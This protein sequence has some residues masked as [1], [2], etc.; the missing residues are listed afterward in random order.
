MIESFGL[1]PPPKQ[2]ERTPAFFNVAGQVRLLA[3]PSLA[4]DH[5][6]Q[7]LR[8]SW[9]QCCQGDLIITGQA[10]APDTPVLQ[11]C[12]K[13][14]ENLHPQ[15]YHLEISEQGISVSAAN[16]MGLYYGVLT[17]SQWLTLAMFEEHRPVEQLRCLNIQDWPDYQHRG[18]M[19]DIS[20]TKV[21]TMDEL[22]R[23]I[24]FAASFKIN[25]IQLYME[26][27]FAYEGHD[28]VWKHAS[29]MDGS[30]IESLDAYCKARHIELVPNQNSFGH[31]HQWLKHGAYRDLAECPQGIEHPFSLDNEP[32]SLCPTDARTL[33]L[34]SDLFDQLL[35]HFSS[36]QFNVGLDETFDLGQGR[37][38]EACRERGKTEV[39]LDFLNQI[40]GLIA[41]KGFRM[42]FWGD[43][44]I[45]KPE[46]LERL[47]K[48]VIALEW[49][50]EADH[51][52][53]T[54]GEHFQRSEREFYVC[55]GTS[56][57]SSVI[58]RIDNA[59]AN[60]ASAAKAGQRHG[61]SGYLITDWGDYGHFQP[62]A[63]SWPG[64]LAGAAWS[65]HTASANPDH[66]QP[67][68]AAFSHF[69]CQTTCTKAAEAIWE[70]GRAYLDCGLQPS[71]GSSLFFLLL[72]AGETMAH[73]RLNGLGIE[74]LDRSLARLEQ[75][76]SLLDQAAMACPDEDWVRT[77]L[78]W[79]MDLIGFACELG[80][81]WAAADDH[82]PLSSISA[83]RKQ[84]LRPIL[85]DLIQRFPELRDTRFRQGG[86]KAALRYL[87]RILPFLS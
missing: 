55:P 30:D 23:I 50:Y 64:W 86:T 74:G 8:E 20:R 56:S 24:D 36:R 62:P 21:P 48:D 16:A 6:V 7:H 60:L 33:P 32:F 49:G 67:I 81:A 73:P 18:L 63:I 85:A 47:P 35:P 69:V 42:Q 54:H 29:P 78:L 37:S 76:K 38:A 1:W 87:E 77:E 80:K 45:Q 2:I 26:H 68:Q 34:L 70:M 83:E 71:N 11:L 51:P 13:T 46:A 31:F 72:Y 52:F 9:Q 82:E 84:A 15:G 5:A 19:I 27:T 43:I 75:A 61:A 65:W 4:H 25:Q 79:A 40:H 58:G 22:Q 17:L 14:M 12:L 57:W 44:I 66:I 28:T 59:M 53:E 39:Y 3:P 41:A 10:P